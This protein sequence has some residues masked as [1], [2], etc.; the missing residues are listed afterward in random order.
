MIFRSQVAIIIKQK[1]LFFAFFRGDFAVLKHGWI[2]ATRNCATK[3]KINDFE[4]M[5]VPN[6][7]G[8]VRGA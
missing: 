2:L 7:C 1:K 5:L 8:I 3:H 6:L 4:L